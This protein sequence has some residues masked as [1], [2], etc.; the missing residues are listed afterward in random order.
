MSEP[1]SSL[2]EELGLLTR[3]A[4]QLA[5]GDT[6]DALGTLGEHRR[7]FAHTQLAQEREGLFIMARCQKQDANAQR[8]ARAFLA[9]SPAAVLATR[10]EQACQL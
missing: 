9:R 10:V 3:A 7:R 5:R 4:D 2:R 8:T 6:A 1:S